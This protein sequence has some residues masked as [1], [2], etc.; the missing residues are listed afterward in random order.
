[1][2][3]REAEGQQGQDA[4]FILV[5]GNFALRDSKPATAG[6]TRGGGNGFTAGKFIMASGFHAAGGRHSRR[7]GRAIYHTKGGR[8]RSRRAEGV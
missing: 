2:A 7:D 4:V 5:P 8:R 6:V 1:L 3:A